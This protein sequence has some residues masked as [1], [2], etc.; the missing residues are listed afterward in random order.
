MSDVESKDFEVERI[1]GRRSNPETK[2][3]EYEIKWKGY[4]ASDNTWEPIEHLNC[5]KKLAEFR[6]R[7]SDAART[8]KSSSSK[9][10]S[11]ARKPNVLTTSRNSTPNRAAPTP[12][13]SSRAKRIAR[14]SSGKAGREHD[15]DSRPADRTPVRPRRLAR[16]SWGERDGGGHRRRPVTIT[17]SPP[18]PKKKRAMRKSIP[19]APRSAG[20]RSEDTT[21]TERPAP[22]PAKA[23]AATDDP[24]L[25]DVISQLRAQN[26]ALLD[27]NASL[28]RILAEISLNA[29]LTGNTNILPE[30]PLL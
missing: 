24:A 2:R 20:S 27:E 14:K 25:A 12:G 13:S 17:E 5:P 23:A 8:P 29:E 9:R 6:R 19:K 18:P 1:V 26:L 21:E 3:V 30:M 11:P 28:K 10:S 15:D 4:A 22:P 16:K 7:S